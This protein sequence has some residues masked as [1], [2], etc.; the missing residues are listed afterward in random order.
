LVALY[1]ID[2]NLL[3]MVIRLSGPPII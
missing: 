1:L 3:R 2:S